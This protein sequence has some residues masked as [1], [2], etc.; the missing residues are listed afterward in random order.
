MVKYKPLL[1]TLLAAVLVSCSDSHFFV[2]TDDL[3][4]DEQCTDAS[5]NDQ[6]PCRNIDLIARV[7][8]AE[9]QGERLNDI[10]GWTDP[11]TGKEYALVG[12]TDGIS[13]VDIS[14][15]D[16]PVVVGTMA[17]SIPDEQNTDRSYKTEEGVHDEEKSTWRDLKVY[18]NHVFVVSD[19][20]P[21]GMQVFDLRRLRDVEDPPRAFTEDYH[22]EEFANA[23]NIAINEETGYAYVVGSDTYG[24]GLHIIDIQEPL[25]PQFA[26]FHSD[27]TVGYRATG[28]V[29]DTQCVIYQGPDTDYTGDEICF[30]SS[31]THLVIANVTDKDSVYTIAKLSYAGGQ[32]AHQGW[33]TE[34]HQYFLLNDELDEGRRN[35]NTRTYIFDVRDLDNPDITGTH[36]AETTSIDHNLYIKGNYVYQA[37]YTAGL[38]ILSL[39][40]VAEGELKEVAWIDTHPEDDVREYDGAWSNYPYFDS[41]LVVVS[42][43]SRGLFILLPRLDD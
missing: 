28:Y 7:T 31:E 8:L 40:N 10:W 18:S 33:L 24:G 32:Y 29:H 4:P 37:N 6:Y 15:P 43:M 19:G 41:G 9:L 13:F 23:H 38:R 35:H 30:N 39:E 21:H 26:G 5:S 42:D 12:M 34:D 20:Q 3:K 11:L 17:E 22:Y 36:T 25:Q 14:K 2:N 16:E 27:S 1:L